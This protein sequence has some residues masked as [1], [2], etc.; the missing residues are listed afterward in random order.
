M[1]RT[2][3]ELPSLGIFA[4]L[5][6]IFFG[7]SALLAWTAFR[8]PA[9]R[10]VGH[11]TGLVAPFFTSVAVLFALLTGFLASD[12]SDR[13]R[14]A[15]RATQVE[16]SELRN[17][18]TLSIASASDMQM[19][20]NALKSY[21]ASVVSD[22][23]PA[24]GEARL[25][26]S[27]DAAYDT[28]LREVSNPAIARSSGPAVHVAL[29]NA[30]VRVGT[31][32]ADRLAIASDYTSGVKWIVVLVL[33]L[34]TQLAIALVHLDKPRAFVVALVVFSGAV[35]VALGLIALQEYPFYGTFRLPSTPI[36]VLQALPDT[37]APALL[38]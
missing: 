36:A 38:R 24:M 22:E 12:I 32:R 4:V 5:I 2:W 28:L 3:L 23:W 8:S 20:R 15:F 6:V 10:I 26:P 31:A 21:I 13:N 19:I 14:Q 9:S 27:T 1:I 30:T 7:M 29:L 17:I 34:F 11:W 25:S 35:I 33:A 37:P 18:Y 16:A